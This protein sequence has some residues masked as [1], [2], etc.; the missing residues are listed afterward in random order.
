[1]NTDALRRLWKQAFGDPDAFLDGFFSAGFSPK[2]CATIEKDGHLAAM[3]FWF[4]CTWED[5]KVAYLYAVATDKDYRN[6]GLCRALM[7]HSHRHLQSLGYAGALLV[8]GSRALFSLYEKLGYVPF[9]NAQTVTVQAGT[10]PAVFAHLAPAEYG[11]KRAPL[12]PEGSVVQDGETLEFLST[13]CGLYE[14]EDCLFSGGSEGNTFFFQ[15]FLG[16]TRRLPHILRA[17]GAEKG[18]LRIPGDT[19]FA[20]YHPLDGTKALPSYFDIP[21]N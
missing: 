19:P 5:R 12:L 20:M 1:M 21:L 8:P 9:C 11:K 2:R 6:Q 16:N 14:S 7:E 4:D 17:L 15:E 13:F 3:L 18:V 10:S